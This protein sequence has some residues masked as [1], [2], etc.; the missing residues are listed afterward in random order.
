MKKLWIIALCGAGLLS[1]QNAMVRQSRVT[2]F[3]AQAA[4]GTATS[5]AILLP[6]YS[7]FGVLTIVGS[8]ITGSPSG[9]QIALSLQQSLGGTSSTAFAT[10]AFTPGNSYQGFFI[11]P[12]SNIYS[13]GD[14]LLAAFT[15]S[16]YPSAGTIS[17]AFNSNAPVTILGTVPLPAGAA[18][19]ANQAYQDPCALNVWTYYPVNVSSNTQIAAAVAGTYYYVCEAIFPNQAGAVNVQLM[20]GTGTACASNTAGLMGGTTAALGANITANG[21]FIAGFAGGR[22]VAATATANHELCIFASASVNGVVAY[23]ASTTAP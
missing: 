17:V 12:S 23:V 6:N 19:A 3:N 22:A 7:A 16:V 10:Q 18:T 5:S 15:C 14:S 1:A 11:T 8:G 20:E 13:G 4:T 2:L 9:C 21:G